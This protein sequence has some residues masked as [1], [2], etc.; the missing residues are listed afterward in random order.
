MRELEQGLTRRDHPDRKIYGE[1]YETRF[2]HIIRTGTVDVT[3]Q[4]IKAYNQAVKPRLKD[5]MPNRQEIIATATA[6]FVEAMKALS[7]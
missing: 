2:E 3:S 7:R 5:Y 6:I 4:V 1:Q